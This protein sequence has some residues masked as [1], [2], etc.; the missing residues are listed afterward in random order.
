MREE[1]TQ[2]NQERRARAKRRRQAAEDDA[3]R[4]SLGY[5]VDSEER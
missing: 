4:Q 3:L 1:L 5:A 2:R